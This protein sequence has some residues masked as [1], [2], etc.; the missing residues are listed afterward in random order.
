[1]NVHDQLNRPFKRIHFRP[2]GGGKK[3]A[4]I[5]ARDVQRRLD[6]VFGWDGW[7]TYYDETQSGRVICRLSV[8]DS[9]KG[10]WITKSDCAGDT[11]VEGEKGAASDAFKRA[12]VSFGIGRYLYNMPGDGTIPHWATP[13]GFDEVMEKRRLDENE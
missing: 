6:E 5:D 9:D 10:E 4:Y 11:A 12:A 7:Q 8:Y 1:M 13:E 3:L 2:G